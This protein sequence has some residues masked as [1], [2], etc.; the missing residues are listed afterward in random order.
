MKTLFLAPHSDDEVLFGAFT[1]MR[2]KPDVIICTSDPDRRTAELRSTETYHAMEELGA[3]LID[4]RFWPHREGTLD[5]DTVKLDLEAH[6]PRKFSPVGDV[7]TIHG[8]YE[9]VF[10]PLPEV[11]GHDEHNAVGTAALEIFG[12]ERTAFYTTYTR[13]GFRTRQG[14]EVPFT[15]EMLARKLRAL[16]QYVTQMEHKDRRPWFVELLDPREW[17]MG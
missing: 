6:A 10:A 1:I 14:A 17:I 16:S 5:V 13:S 7:S 12:P 15:T 11:N 3:G 8:G 9:A 2:F 4:V